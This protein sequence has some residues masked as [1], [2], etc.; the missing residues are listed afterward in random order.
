MTAILMS[1]VLLGLAVTLCA[2]SFFARFDSL[3]REYARVA[4]GLAESCAQVA[5]LRVAQDYHYDPTADA[6]YMAGRGVA[7]SID[8]DEQEVP[9]T[10]AIVSIAY[11]PD[12][13]AHTETATI[14]SRGQYR[15]SFASV[16]VVAVVTDPSYATSNT[17]SHMSIV[18]WQRVQ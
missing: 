3:S 11:I 13:V 1:V 2:S 18:S 8:V 16:R 6:Q 7:V 4:Q 14:I 10:C 5:L 9:E 15:D 17:A 12:V